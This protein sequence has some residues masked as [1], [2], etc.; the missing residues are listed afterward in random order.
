MPPGAP[1]QIFYDFAWISDPT[2]WAGLLTLA[3]IQIVLGIDNLVFIAVLSAKL[4]PRE[5]ARARVIGIETAKM[6]VDEWLAATYE[7]GRHQT[8]IDM[9]SEIETTQSLRAAEEQN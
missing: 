2:A 7:G 6:I 8:R 9:I 5:R 4:P 1:A 3:L